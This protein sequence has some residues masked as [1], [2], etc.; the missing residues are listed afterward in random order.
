MPGYLRTGSGA[1]S[2]ASL[3]AG[4]SNTPAGLARPLAILL[5]GKLVAMPTLAGSPVSSAMVAVSSRTVRSI[6]ASSLASSSLR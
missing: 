5:I 6:A 3:P 2:S 1:S 4:T